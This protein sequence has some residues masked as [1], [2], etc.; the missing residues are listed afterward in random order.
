MIPTSFAR[1][2]VAIFGLVV[3]ICAAGLIFSWQYQAN[4]SDRARIDSAIIDAGGRSHKSSARESV[5][6]VE[7]EYERDK[8]SIEN[9]NKINE[10]E[11]ANDSAGDAGVIGLDVVCK[12][13]IYRHHPACMQR[14]NPAAGSGKR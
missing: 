12:R 14:E 1:K 8:Q 11:N 2:T 5:A 7:R 4:K 6:A 10:A 13:A 3:L 9:R